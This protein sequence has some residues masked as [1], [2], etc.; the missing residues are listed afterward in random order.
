MRFIVFA[1][2][3]VFCLDGCS[4]DFN[5]KSSSVSCV[6]NAASKMVGGNSSIGADSVDFKSASHYKMSS[7][8]EDVT[9]PSSLTGDNKLIT[10]TNT[11]NCSQHVETDSSGE[12]NTFMNVNDGFGGLRLRHGENRIHYLVQKCTSIVY[13]DYKCVGET[14]REEG[15]MIVDAP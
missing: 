1:V 10:L 6:A 8:E 11:S 5:G 13:G 2:V 15:V 12:P 14:A 4:L 7:L 3:A 9:I